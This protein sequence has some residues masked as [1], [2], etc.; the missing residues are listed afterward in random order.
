[1]KNVPVNIL[2]TVVVPASDHWQG[3]Q[4]DSSGA[5]TQD[6]EDLQARQTL[7]RTPVANIH[8]QRGMPCDKEISQLP[9]GNH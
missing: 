4:T 9:P 8:A 7:C 3:G 2:Y 6:H 5:R 1:M